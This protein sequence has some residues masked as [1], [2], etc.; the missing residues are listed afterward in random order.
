M[1]T[2]DQFL[3]EKTSDLRWPGDCNARTLDRKAETDRCY[4]EPGHS[5][6]KV[7]ERQFGTTVTVIPRH[8]AMNPYTCKA[9]IKDLQRSC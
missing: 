4:I 6:D 1:M 3:D 2:F 7:K 5:H 9:I 8:K